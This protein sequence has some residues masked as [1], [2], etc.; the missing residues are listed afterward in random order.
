MLNRIQDPRL[1]PTGLC[2]VALVLSSDSV[3][4]QRMA[5]SFTIEHPDRLVDGTIEVVWTCESLVSE[6]NAAS[7]RARALRSYCHG[8]FLLLVRTEVSVNFTSQMRCVP[9]CANRPVSLPR[10]SQP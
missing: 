6:M 10:R 9:T 2:A 7:D 3:V 4:G 8:D 5:I 1:I